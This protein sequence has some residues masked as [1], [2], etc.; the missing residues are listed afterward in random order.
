MFTTSIMLKPIMHH[1]IVTT[2]IVTIIILTQIVHHHMF[3][4]IVIWIKPVQAKARL[5][6]TA[7]M[8]CCQCGCEIALNERGEP[9][10]GT[11]KNRK[12]VSDKGCRPV[13]VCVHC[14]R[15]GARM[16]KVMDTG[17]SLKGCIKA[18]SKE[19]R[20]EWYAKPREAIHK[21]W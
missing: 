1:P 13:Y 17:P 7:S 15:L 19:E 8:T 12:R 21:T 6:L 16:H 3:T 20:A 10:M 18:F 5:A 4:C 9:S 11:W 14:N 2:A